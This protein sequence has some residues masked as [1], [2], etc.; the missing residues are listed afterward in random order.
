MTSLYVNLRITEA[1]NFL[2]AEALLHGRDT[3]HNEIVTSKYQGFC[4]NYTF[5]YQWY[6]RS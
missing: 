4:K 5:Q 3:F 6:L 1:N 2:M